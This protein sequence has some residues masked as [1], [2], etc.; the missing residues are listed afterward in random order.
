VLQLAQAVSSALDGC[1]L[2]EDVSPICHA[3]SVKNEVELEGM[4]SC[5][6]RDAVALCEYFLWLETELA[7]GTH[8]TEVTAGDKLEALRGE[9]TGCV[10]L[11]FC[12][13]W[14]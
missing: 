13:L 6:R 5:H 7:Q 8:I 9:Q 4:R 3:K 11:S 2:C 14:F 12:R 10:P 1:K